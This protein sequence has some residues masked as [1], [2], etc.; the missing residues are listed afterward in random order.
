MKEQY[1]TENFELKNM[2]CKRFQLCQ[3]PLSRIFSCLAHS[4]YF[5]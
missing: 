2:V 4:L 3:I 5:S 1:E